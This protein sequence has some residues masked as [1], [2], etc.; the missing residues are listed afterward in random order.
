MHF[1]KE[2][3][4]RADTSSHDPSK[5]SE[6]TRVRGGGGR[7]GEKQVGAPGNIV[8]TDMGPNAGTRT[9]WAISQNSSPWSAV[10]RPSGITA[11]RFRTAP[12]GNLT[13][14]LREHSS[15]A[16]SWPVTKTG[17]VRPSRSLTIGP[18]KEV[19]SAGTG[20]SG[21]PQEGVWHNHHIRQRCHRSCGC[22]LPGRCPSD[23]Q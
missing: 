7:L 2:S 21:G 16:R 12:A 10:K 14:S 17:S 6:K 11:F 13:K 1:C 3:Q 22:C 20:H 18:A 4:S 5:R 9:R 15:L 8:L 23:C 19:Q